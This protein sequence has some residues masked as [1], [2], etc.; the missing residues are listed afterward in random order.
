MASLSEC[1]AGFTVHGGDHHQLHTKAKFKLSDGVKARGL[2]GGDLTPYIGGVR[3]APHN[4]D[5]TR[6][7]R[8]QCLMARRPGSRVG[9]LCRRPPPLHGRRPPPPPQ[10]FHFPHRQLPTAVLL[11]PYCAAQATVEHRSAAGGKAQ[12]MAV[13]L[14]GKQWEVQHEIGGKGVSLLLF[15]GIA[16]RGLERAGC[17]LRAGR[18]AGCCLQLLM[19]LIG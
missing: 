17:L 12:A 7:A 18:Y 11:P 8:S 6:R 14:A 15:V 4:L 9:G 16:C 10:P 2:R 5:G 13:S 3:T 19:P 1:G